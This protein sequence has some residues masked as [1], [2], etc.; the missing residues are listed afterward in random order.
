MFQKGKQINFNF[1]GRAIEIVKQ[2][3]T[4]FVFI[5]NTES[6]HDFSKS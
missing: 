3:Q 5:P 4:D 1:S 6:M 2:N